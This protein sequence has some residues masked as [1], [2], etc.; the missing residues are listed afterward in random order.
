[1]AILLVEDNAV[2]LR[3]ITAMLQALGYQPATATDGGAGLKALAT[4]RFDLVLM[5]V[6]MP[7]LDGFAATRALRA[8]EAGELNRQTRVV[9]LTANASNEDRDACLASGMNAFLTKPI[10]RPRLLEVLSAK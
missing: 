9:A 1:M 2:N 3:L 4:Q 10:E 6:Q 7:V 8:G 5:D